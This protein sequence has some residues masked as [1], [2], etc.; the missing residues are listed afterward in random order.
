VIGHAKRAAAIVGIVAAVS[1]MIGGGMV[2]AGALQ[3]SGVSCASMASDAA[4]APRDAHRA[5]VVIGV[6]ANSQS[7]ADEASTLVAEALASDTPGQQTVA[8]I[9]VVVGDRAFLPQGMTCIGRDLLVSAAATDLN[10]Y[11][12]ASSE[13][14]SDLA[15]ELVEQYADQTAVIA[16]EIR[17]AIRSAPQPGPNSGVFFTWPFVADVPADRDAFVLDVFTTAGDNCLTI[18]DPTARSADGSLVFGTRVGECV[19]G[20]ELEV[21]AARSVR[22][23]A[24]EALSLSGGQQQAQRTVMDALCAQAVAGGC[25]VHEPEDGAP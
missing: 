19:A 23:R 11:R 1:A 4:S 20:G 22:L 14:R 21:A 13:A 3:G 17:S 24:V 8:K 6:S 7:A 15:D 9:T 5:E 25:A 18:D 2:I 16:D 12:H 10:S